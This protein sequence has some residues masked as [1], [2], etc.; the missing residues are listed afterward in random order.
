MYKDN[1]SCILCKDPQSEENLCHLLNCDFLTS[2]PQLA[3]EIKTI[4]SEDIFGTLV[5]QVEAVKIWDKIFKVYDK[6]KGDLL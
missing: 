1:I 3:N 4:K 5:E 6:V 2:L